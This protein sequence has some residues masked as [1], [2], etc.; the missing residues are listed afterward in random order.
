NDTSASAI[1]RKRSALF[2][3]SVTW[4]KPKLII[5]MSASAG[6][7]RP[8]RCAP[9]R[10]R[11]CTR[12]ILSWRARSIGS[13][14]GW[15]AVPIASEIGVT[16]AM[17]AASNRV[18]TVFGGTGFLGHRIVRHLRLTGFCVRVGSRQPDRGHALLGPDDAQLRS[19]KVDIRDQP[20]VADALTDAY[21]AV[22]AVS[23]YL[24]QGR[25]TF[26]SI[27]VESAQRVAAQAQRA[28]VKKIIHFSGIDDGVRSHSLSIRNT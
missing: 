22:N 13:S 3:T 28:G 2:A 21:G 20:S 26:H 24:E 18:V 4:L 16:L 8:S 17:K 25:E 6:V 11:D 27:H 23:L 12:T 5:P 7:T 14:M 10:S 19:V 1:F 9:R 15:M